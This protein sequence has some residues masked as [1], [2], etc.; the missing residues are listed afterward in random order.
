MLFSSEYSIGVMYMA[1]NYLPRQLRYKRE[2]II[3]AGIIPGPKEPKL[4]LNSFLKPLVE[5]LKEFWSGITIPCNNHPLKIYLF[6]QHLFAVL[7]IYQPQKTLGLLDTQ[8]H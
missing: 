6:E 1:V 7:V 2:N 3:L 8:Q 5:D 4:T